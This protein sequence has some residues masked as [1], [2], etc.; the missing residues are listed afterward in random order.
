[1]ERSGKDSKAFGPS[2]VK[3]SYKFLLDVIQRP[4]PAVHKA[5]RDVVGEGISRKGWKERERNWG[6]GKL[7]FSYFSFSS[8]IVFIHCCPLNSAPINDPR[9]REISPACFLLLN[10]FLLFSFR[11]F[12]VSR[13]IWMALDRRKNYY[14]RNFSSSFAVIGSRWFQS[15]L[16]LRSLRK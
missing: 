5:G 1:M 2:I 3:F 14:E 11:S 7:C 13:E 15:K 8:T 12:L 9:R 4:H 6:E 16:L 10:I